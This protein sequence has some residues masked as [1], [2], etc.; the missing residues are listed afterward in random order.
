MS[1]VPKRFPIHRETMRYEAP[2]TD[3][4]WELISSHRTQCL[5]N[6]SQS[7]E[8]LARRGGLYPPEMLAVIHDETYWKNRYEGMTLDD[9]F[10]ELG[11]IVAD[12]GEAT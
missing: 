1:D 12:L 8:T 2:F 7:P 10:A 6:H 11:Q 9:A 3:V 5:R 4:P